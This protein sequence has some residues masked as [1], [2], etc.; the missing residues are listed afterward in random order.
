M[1]IDQLFGNSRDFLLP[2]EFENPDDVYRSIEPLVVIGKE[3]NKNVSAY[4][5]GI[6]ETNIEYKK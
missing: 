1:L 6:D 5:L 2:P 4:F 3:K